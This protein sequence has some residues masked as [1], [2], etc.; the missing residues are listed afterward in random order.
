VSEIE[1]T[2]LM[3]LLTTLLGVVAGWGAIIIGVVSGSI[4]WITMNVFGK[5]LAFF[6]AVDDVLGVVHTHMVAGVCGGFL[7]GIFSTSQGAIAFAA[8]S[9]GG[10]ITGHG[11]QIGWQLAGA[12]FIIGWNV[13]WTSLICLFIKYVCRVPLRMS[14]EDLMIGD[15]AIHGE[16]A[17]AFLDENVV[18]V[19][20]PNSSLIMGESPKNSDPENSGAAK[21]A[22]TDNP[23][24]DVAARV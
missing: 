17:Y 18:D 24:I 5:R 21:E 19:E 9:P 12:C 14:D 6:R 10:G 11:V 23:E 3:W 13:V 4:P 20:D 8:L 15:D 16:A 1:I 2:L 22:A 7:V